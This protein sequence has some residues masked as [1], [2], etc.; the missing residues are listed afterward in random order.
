MHLFI[1]LFK[2]H[3]DIRKLHE[4][5]TEMYAYQ[6]TSYMTQSIFSIFKLKNPATACG[7]SQ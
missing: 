4:V 7:S 2:P 3:L 5:D 6:Y 1:Q